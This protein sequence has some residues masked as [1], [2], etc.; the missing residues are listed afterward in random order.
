MRASTDQGDRILQLL[1]VGLGFPTL[2][3]TNFTLARFIL[4]V[5]GPG[6]VQEL[7]RD[8][9]SRGEEESEA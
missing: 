9:Q 1:A 7:I 5:G 4:D 2:I 3:R 6:Y 8:G